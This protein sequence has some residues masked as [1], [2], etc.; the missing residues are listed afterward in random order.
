MI[1]LKRVYFKLVN[2]SWMV[3]AV[4][5]LLLIVG[6]TISLTIIEPQTFTNHL[7]ALWFTMTTML[8]VGYGDISPV[9]AGGKIFTII[10]LFTIGVGLFATFIG[11][12]LD[13]L[14]TYHKKRLRGDIMYTG[15]NHYVI[16]DWS[17]K[18]ENAVQE[19]IRRDEK[20]EIVVIDTMDTLD[21]ENVHYIK[22]SAS[23]SKVL[24]KANVANAIA[25]IIFA[26]EKID[27]QMLRDGKSL[28]IASAIERISSNIHTT[29]EIELEEHLES[30]EHINIDKFI[31]ANQTLARIIVDSL[32]ESN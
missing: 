24:K 6:S 26:D 8:T 29:V 30:F 17:H 16:I 10:F 32:G 14:T 20:A 27:S 23:N 18:A 12:I 3:L 19:I 2:L 13:S 7:D 21:V 25:V 4:T 1:L 28:M 9:T 22:G 11:K 31:L 15:K 5:T